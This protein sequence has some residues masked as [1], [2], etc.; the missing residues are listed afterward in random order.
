M[1][2]RNILAIFQ[3]ELQSYFTSP[4][5]YG[6]MTIFWFLA[7]IFFVVLL[8]S[9]IEEGSMRQQLGFPPQDL[10]LQF[11]TTYLGVMGSL[12][13]FLL[14]MLS[15]GLYAEER[16][17]G[18]LELLATSPVTNW[19]V[20]LGKLWGVVTFFTTM[21][22]PMMF[23]EFLV[24]ASTEPQLNPGVVLLA[25]GGLWLL[26]TAILSL[27]MWVSCLSDSSLFA[28]ILTF[29]LILLLWIPEVLADNLSGVWASAIAYLSLMKHYN[30]FI[31]GVFD[32]GSLIAFLS[33]IGLGVFLTAQSIEALRFS[34]R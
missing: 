30:H 27:G 6:I 13:L 12:V 16:K 18:T 25:H 4:L 15:M 34:R 31:Q 23:Y 11:V 33:Y 10:G 26:A 32:S 8:P 17:R 5:A 9:V 19:A 14:P 29:A 2:F 3:K 22:V 21:M 7:G 24:L 20:A 28:A 1:I